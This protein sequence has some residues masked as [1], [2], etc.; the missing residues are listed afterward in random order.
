MENPVKSSPLIFNYHTGHGYDVRCSPT[1]LP[2]WVKEFGL[3]LP[4]PFANDVGGIRTN[5]AGRVS[6][7]HVEVRFT[8][9]NI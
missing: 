6:L 7:F 5:S 1:L 4:C 2:R 3:D 8:V 9:S